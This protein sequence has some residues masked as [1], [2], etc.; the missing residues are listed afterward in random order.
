MAEVKITIPDDKVARVRDAICGQF[1]YAEELPG[2]TPNPVS[3]NQF[4]K[5]VIKAFIKDAVI[6]YEA[7]KAAD[8]A[9]KAAIAAADSE[10]DIGD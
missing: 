5:N 1:G 3:K 8:L 2:G 10:I 9:K 6:K 4:V 7:A